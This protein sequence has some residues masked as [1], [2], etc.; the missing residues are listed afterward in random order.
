[1][2]GIAVSCEQAK[3][4]C[5]WVSMSRSGEQ[6]DSEQALDHEA[7]RLSQSGS[8]A[9]ELGAEI[10]YAPDSESPPIDF[11][12]LRAFVR[13]E[14][15]AAAARDVAHLV[16][17]YRPWHTAWCDIVQQNVSPPAP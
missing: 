16:A 15:D 4:I 11:R 2:A 3:S 9:D 6:F 8:L 12:A 13:G 1:M 10:R 17:V 14:L 5:W 7:Q